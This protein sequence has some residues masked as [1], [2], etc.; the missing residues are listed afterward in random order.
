MVLLLDDAREGRSEKPT[1]QMQIQIQIQIQ[2]QRVMLPAIA[3]QS[4]TDWNRTSNLLDAIEAL[5]CLSYDPMC[6]KEMSGVE[7]RG[8]APRSLPC[9]SSVLLLNYRPSA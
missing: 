8:I 6:S 9:E 3:R 1:T 7:R 5:S 4:G 2:I